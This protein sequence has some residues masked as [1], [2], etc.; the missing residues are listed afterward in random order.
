MNLGETVIYCGIEGNSY[1]LLHWREQLYI[2]IWKY[3]YM[4]ASLCR[5]CVLNVFGVTV[6]FDVDASHIFPRGVLSTNLGWRCGW[7]YRRYSLY[8]VVMEL[9]LTEVDALRV[10]LQLALFH[11]NVCFS[12][13]PHWGLCVKGGEC[14]SGACVLAE[15]LNIASVGIC[16]FAQTQS[17]FSS[18]PCYGP[19]RSSARLWCR[20]DRAGAF[21]WLRL[22]S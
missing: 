14:W 18:F 1:I 21:A 6:V 5:P 4:G 16:G 7:H 20:V 15:V 2:V 9:S 11:L 22:G 3:F 17:K 19:P 8:S 13:S 10:G 12:F